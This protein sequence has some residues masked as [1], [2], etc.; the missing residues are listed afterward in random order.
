MQD[1]AWLC[2]EALDQAL[3]NNDYLVGS[4]FS[5]ADIVNGYSLLLAERYV[6]RELPTRLASYW[7]T[8]KARPA[9]QSAVA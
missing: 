6:P 5:A 9:Y 1:R 4:E 3:A 2:I 7:E 8:L